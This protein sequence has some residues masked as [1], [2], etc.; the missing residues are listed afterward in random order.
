LPSASISGAPAGVVLLGNSITLTAVPSGGT[1]P[2]TFAWTKNGA[3]FATTAAITD[4]PALGSTV[5]GVTI[6]D[7]LGA[8]SNTATTTVQVYDFTVSGSPASLQVLTTGM[9]T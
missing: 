9:N 5:Y 8:V 2:F 3:P 7:S 4:T 1:G 6:T